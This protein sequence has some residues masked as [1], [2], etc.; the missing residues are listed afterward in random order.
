ME[1]KIKSMENITDIVEK[2]G[3]VME[4]KFEKLDER[5]KEIM[6]R[7]A[8]SHASIE[9][10]DLNSLRGG[11]DHPESSFSVLPVALRILHNVLEGL[12]LDE[13]EVI[14]M[15]GPT[16]KY[17]GKFVE[18]K[19]IEISET[20]TP[21][22]ITDLNKQFG[23]NV[24][25]KV[26]DKLV[27]KLSKEISKHLVDAKIFAPYLMVQSISTISEGTMNPRIAMR[28][29]Y[30]TVMR[31]RKD[32]DFR[33]SAFVGRLTEEVSLLSNKALDHLNATL[34]REEFYR[35][36]ETNDFGLNNN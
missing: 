5:R 15:K 26:E 29:R 10:K 27:S 18:A 32:V 23:I 7:Y 19:T 35:K 31:E 21:D 33:N 12:D 8:D 22:E 30:G 4:T 13:T 28:S 9:T 24:V 17:N 36:T 3:P 34:I 11:F 14:I 2:W 25:Q 20:I 6:C 16:G 1:L